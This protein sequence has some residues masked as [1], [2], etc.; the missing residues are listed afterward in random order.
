MAG[1]VFGVD[2]NF[3]CPTSPFGHDSYVF[4]HDKRKVKN[5]HSRNFLAGIQE[6]KNGSPTGNLGDDSCVPIRA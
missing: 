4:R 5:C 6:K 3:G 2:L 1:F